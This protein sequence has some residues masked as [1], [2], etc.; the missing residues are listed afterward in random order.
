MSSLNTNF[1]CDVILNGNDSS[2][3]GP[4]ATI[5][6]AV[7]Y[8]TTNFALASGNH[9][10]INLGPGIFTQSISVTATDE[11]RFIDYVGAGINDTVL[12][13]T[14]SAFV[15]INNSTA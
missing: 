2:P 15:T 9:G 1:A 7:T 3:A 5:A 12:E 13:G 10:T 6:A 14:T 8:L 11:T 4:F